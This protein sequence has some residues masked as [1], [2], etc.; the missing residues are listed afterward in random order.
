M[1]HIEDLIL[2]TLVKIIS[3]EVSISS[4]NMWLLNPSSEFVNSQEGPN[5]VSKVSYPVIGIHYMSDVVYKYNNYGENKYIYDSSGNVT[6]YSPLGEVKMPLGISLYAKSRKDMREYG[7]KLY[8]F[9]LKNKFI[10]LQNDCVTGEYFALKF[11]TKKDTYEEMPYQEIYIIECA[12]RIFK[13]TFAPR[14]DEIVVTIDTDIVDGVSCTNGPAYIN[15]DAEIFEP[16]T[17]LLYDETAGVYYILD[18]FRDGEATYI[19]SG[20][21]SM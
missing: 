9:L 21:N 6:E 20:A 13:E 15:P 7:D 4:G 18:F 3:D 19:A 8:S 2:Q 14:I 11:L 17:M 10:G 16:G 5:S 12:S 1:R